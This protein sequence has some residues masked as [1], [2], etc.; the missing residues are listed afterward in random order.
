MTAGG[1]HSIYS[2]VRDSKYLLK[3]ESA[4]ADLGASTKA[5][6]LTAYLCLLSIIGYDSEVLIGI[7]TNSRPPCEDSDQILGCFLN[8][9]P[10]TG[11]VDPDLLCSEL[12]KRVNDKLIELK[13]YERLSLLEIAGIHGERSGSGNPFFDVV[14][15]YID[16]HAY[17]NIEGDAA[18]NNSN[19]YGYEKTN[20]FFDLTINT[21]GRKYNLIINAVKKL[22]GLSHERTEKL[23]FEILDY[24]I[25]YPGKKITS[26]FRRLG[27]NNPD[28]G[29]LSLLSSIDHEETA[30]Y[31]R[32][33]LKNAQGIGIAPVKKGNG[34]YV[35]GTKTIKLSAKRVSWI[36]SFCAT[37]EVHLGSFF[38]TIWGLLLSKAHK[39][40]DVLFATLVPDFPE[41]NS[42][43]D[44][45]LNA[46]PVK[47]T[48]IM[49]EPISK[50][51]KNEGRDFALNSRH[52]YTSTGRLRDLPG[53]GTVFSDHL[54]AVLDAG[55]SGRIAEGIGLSGDAPW[56]TRFYGEPAYD[57]LLTVLSDSDGIRLRFDHNKSS[58]S[59]GQ[60][61]LIKERLLNIMNAIMRSGGGCEAGRIIGSSMEDQI[62]E[63]GF[64]MESNF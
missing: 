26:L 43:P 19:P 31:W 54:L 14:F 50:L 9:V 24:M 32:A 55:G 56:L 63:Y 47:I 11:K 3:V 13:G 35:P 38:R 59:T 52:H 51:M 16:F 42:P 58:F 44:L 2:S 20:T 34:P 10:F 46:V 57:L 15:D 62:D 21:T 40:N 27:E 25:E 7:V 1:G 33:I 5:I 8:T 18:G 29:Y 45:F 12:I 61:L 53:S 64:K 17:E 41:Q 28:S 37:E 36:R 6:S 4:A 39:T 30:A 22:R 60:I 48:F 49:N 23:Y